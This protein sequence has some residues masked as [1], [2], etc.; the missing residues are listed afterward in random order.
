[1]TGEEP[2]SVHND[3]RQDAQLLL[4]LDPRPDAATEQAD[5]FWPDD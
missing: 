5:N 3:A 2:Y 1:M 4:V